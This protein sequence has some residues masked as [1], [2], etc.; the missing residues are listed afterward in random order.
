[1]YRHILI[2][3]AFD[4][5]HEPAHSLDVAKALAGKDTRV[6]L[7]HVQEP[8]PGYAV[9]Y[10]PQHY[11][12]EMQEAI[13]AQL[14][15]LAA[16]FKNAKGVLVEGHTGRAILDWAENNDVDCIIIDSHRP[17]LQ[18]YLLGSTAARVVRHAQC[19]VHVI[20]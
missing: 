14:N 10:I 15:Q 9:S 8:I 17:G 11:A 16:S 19:S 6:S 7:L 1:M 20:R 2:A 13:L 18:D 5:E 4:E 3:V 12:S